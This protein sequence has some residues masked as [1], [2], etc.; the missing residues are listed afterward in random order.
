MM[1]VASR[2]ADRP[3]IETLGPADSAALL[4]LSETI[5]WPH[6]PEDWKVVLE[7]AQVFGHRANGRSLASSGALFRYGATLASIGMVLVAPAHR[8]RGLARA[9]MEHCL[10]AASASA[11]TLIA[12]P[13]GEPLY[14]TLGFVEVARI[15]RL[16]ADGGSPSTPLPGLGGTEDEVARLDREAFG[17]DRRAVLRTALARAAAG[18]GLRDARGGLRGFGVAV[19]QREMLAIGP[20]IAPD[21]ADALALVRSL[22]AAANGR[23][24]MDVPTGRTEFIEALGELGFRAFDDAPVMLYGGAALPGR[25]DRLHAIASRAFG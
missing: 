20:V 22:V 13:Q 21:T 3:A 11:V 9:V 19:R 17:A 7:T 14:R 16:V 15:R 2:D 18:A 24:R 10:V 23:I 12:T 6:T 1:S 8:R 25:R 4:A 5:G